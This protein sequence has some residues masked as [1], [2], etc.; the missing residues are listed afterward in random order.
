MSPTLVAQGLTGTPLHPMPT[1]NLLQQAA[2]LP[3][4]WRSHIVSELGYSQ[5]KILRMDGQ[6]SEEETH[7]Y[8]EAFVV[9]DGQLQLEVAGQAVSVQAGELY[10]VNAGVPHSVAAGSWGALL[11]VDP[12]A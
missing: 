12:A 4:A 7:P 2:R 9:L 11:I 5:L 8:D 10:T 6:P 3:Q 1:S